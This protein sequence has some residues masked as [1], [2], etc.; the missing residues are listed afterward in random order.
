VSRALAGILFQAGGAIC[1]SNAAGTAS[2]IESPFQIHTD[3]EQ[4]D[5]LGAALF[6]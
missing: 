6:A 4:Q 1:P 5:Y 3:I 2:E